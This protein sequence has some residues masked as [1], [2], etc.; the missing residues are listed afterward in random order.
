MP[1]RK[2]AEEKER[3]G[4]GEKVAKVSAEEAVEMVRGYLGEWLG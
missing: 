2:K 3:G 4:G 1:P